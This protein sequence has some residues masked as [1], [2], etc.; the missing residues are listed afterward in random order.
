M[1]NSFDITKKQSIK[2]N[3]NSN[4]N[5]ILNN[6]AHYTSNFNFPV[7][8][9]SQSNNNSSELSKEECNSLKP[10]DSKLP[11]IGR[12]L[13]E[14]DY[15]ETHSYV[16]PIKNN[17]RRL[18]KYFGNKLNTLSNQKVEN[19][20]HN[21]LKRR[22]TFDE[23]LEQSIE[24]ELENLNCVLGN[25]GKAFNKPS[26]P[27]EFRKENDNIKV[28]EELSEKNKEENK[29]LKKDE[30][31]INNEKK[32][33][34]EESDYKKE[35]NECEKEQADISVESKT[36]KEI[37]SNKNIEKEIVKDNVNENE[38]SKKRKEEF[39]TYDEKE[40]NF[41]NTSNN[42]MMNYIKFHHDKV[43]KGVLD[44]HL[45][46][47]EKIALLDHARKGPEF[48]DSVKKQNEKIYIEYNHFCSEMNLQPFPVNPI[49]SVSFFYFL[50]KSGMYNVGSIDKVVNFSL[51][52]LNLMITGKPVDSY[53]TACMKAEIASLYRDKSVKQP[54]DGMTPII[55]SDMKIIL[56]TI[57]DVDPNKPMLS[58]MFLFALATGSRA[59]T[60]A[61]VKLSHLVYYYNRKDKY[62]NYALTI[63]QSVRKSKRLKY[64]TVTVSGVPQKKDTLNIIY[65]LNLYLNTTFNTNIEELVNHNKSHPN[66]NDEY[67]WPLSPGCMTER[68][69]R[70]AKNAGLNINKVGMH[71][72]RSGFL[73]SAILYNSKNENQL[74]A[75][76][77]MCSVIADWDPYSK[78]QMTY[79]KATSRQS[80]IATDIVG[81]SQTDEVGIETTKTSEN[82]HQITI[83]APPK[84][85]RYSFLVKRKLKE[86]IHFPSVYNENNNNVFNNMYNYSLIR[87]SK[88]IFKGVELTNN[89]YRARI[90]RYMNDKI[91]EDANFINTISEKLLT[92]LK[93]NN[94][95]KVNFEEQ[96]TIK[97]VSDTAKRNNQLSCLS[98]RKVN[99]ARWST[100]ELNI[101]NKGIEERKSL[102]EISNQL[103]FRSYSDCYDHLRSINKRRRN[104]NLP[105]LTTT[106]SIRLKR[107][108][109][110]KQSDHNEIEENKEEVNSQAT[111]IIN[112]Q[113]ENAK[114][115][116]L[117]NIQEK[118]NVTELYN[119]QTE[120][121]QINNMNVE[122][123]TVNS[124]ANNIFN[125]SNNLYLN[126]N[127]GINDLYNNSQNNNYIMSSINFMNCM[128][129]MSYLNYNMMNTNYYLYNMN[130]IITNNNEENT[131]ENS[132]TESKANNINEMNNNITNNVSYAI[133]NNNS[134]S[135]INGNTNNNM[136]C[137]YY[138][139][140]IINPFSNLT[141]FQNNEL[142]SSSIVKENSNNNEDNQ[143]SSTQL[144]EYKMSNMNSTS[145][146]SSINTTSTNVNLP[147]KQ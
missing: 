68:L 95:L 142:Y 58:S 9:K 21:L 106:K 74:R 81:L 12:R 103:Y 63:V 22:R 137:L 13:I 69:K 78:A 123:N 113:F 122:N 144:S 40:K 94:K 92:I 7:F 108:T 104:Q 114:D 6:F 109:K 134:N 72:L 89:Q 16:I 46:E 80:L 125:N 96:E 34:E 10:E 79:I 14:K 67:L 129:Y 131:K 54:G 59:S 1:L 44:I 5:E 147:Y 50:S 136:M 124:I 60:V 86:L 135:Q 98:G 11:D 53:T 30:E 18:T 100:E 64:K 115:T 43:R 126:N 128:N 38:I 28:S 88:E 91:L 71:S 56:D 127:S 61:G 143:S 66:E 145:E 139:C 8:N 102:R 17:K 90:I 47:E 140:Y 116:L 23:S 15:K 146:I 33:R 133:N 101:F 110:N 83:S 41:D 105:I 55:T 57:P 27:Q 117:Q 141:S 4:I 82:F 99:R 39:N 75:V 52:R 76:M 31:N 132:N 19:E 85:K 84:A 48:S 49:T 87:L 73:T 62:G 119:K 93:I 42:A 37:E 24:K 107:N 97:K 77:E 111:S 120:K 51:L 118:I 112:N 20:K 3:G 2:F 65:W 36:L 138:P 35:I 25:Q 70:C 26:S 130:N 32:R 45:T 29:S 121:Q